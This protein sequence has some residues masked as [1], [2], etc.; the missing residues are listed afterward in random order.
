MVGGLPSSFAL[1][2]FPLF[3]FC[4]SVPFTSPHIHTYLIFVFRFAPG[5]R[6]FLR[7]NLRRYLRF[8][9]FC[10]LF[11]FIVFSQSLPSSLSA[12]HTTLLRTLSSG[13]PYLSS[14]FLFFHHLCRHTAAPPAFRWSWM[15]CHLPGIA[16]V[17]RPWMV[18]ARDCCCPSALDGSCPIVVA[19]ITSSFWVPQ[20]A[21]CTGLLCV[22]HL[23]DSCGTVLRRRS[24]VPCCDPATVVTPVP[25][26]GC[27]L[28]PVACWLLLP[29]VFLCLR[30]PPVFYCPCPPRHVLLRDPCLLLTL[31]GS[32]TMTVPRCPHVP[33]MDC[34]Y[35]DY[36]D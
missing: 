15:A 8:S 11:L 9:L 27:T 28:S 14:S 29:A 4:S 34:D 19:A 1:F 16:V 26:S 32:P 6:F 10:L 2:H 25:P 23:R 35:C 13:S 12:P 21:R 3:C 22:L 7:S 17:L 18:P 20:A 30:L 33:R 31:H 36:C 5:A 24:A